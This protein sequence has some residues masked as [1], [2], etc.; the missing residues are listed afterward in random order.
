MDLIEKRIK[1][2]R[3]LFGFLSKDLCAQIGVTSKLISQ[4]ESGKT[5]PYHFAFKNPYTTLH[6]TVYKWM[7]TS[8]FPGKELCFDTVI[9]KKYKCEETEIRCVITHR[10]I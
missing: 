3:E 5:F 2:K 1:Q 7:M 10:I 9:N 4:I 8:Y 6:T